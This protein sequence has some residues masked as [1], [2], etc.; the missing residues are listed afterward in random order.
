VW[1]GGW[2]RWRS[3]IMLK[4]PL[5]LHLLGRGALRV[6]I[7]HKCAAEL[8]STCPP[9]A[10]GPP[11]SSTCFACVGHNQHSLRS[12]GC[13]PRDVDAYCAAGGDRPDPV[14]Q[15]GVVSRNSCC[16]ATCGRCGGPSCGHLPGGAERCCSNAVAA[17]GRSCDQ[18]GPPCVIAN[19]PPPA[20]PPDPGDRE[21]QVH[22]G[23]AG[24]LVARVAEEFV[25]FNID[26]SQLGRLDLSAPLL[27][28]LAKALGPAHLR[29]GGTQADYNVYAFGAY[30]GFDCKRPP[31]PMTSY[32]CRVVTPTMWTEL[33]DFVQQTDL[34]L[35]YGLNNL[36]GRP[37]KTSPETKLCGGGDPAMDACPVRNQSNLEALLAWTVHS[38]P[39]AIFGL[40]LGNELNTCL[41]GIA[42]AQTQA[43]DF[44]ALGAL[45]RRLWSGQ[46]PSHMPI[47]IG[48]DT[49]SAVEYHLQNINIML[50]TTLE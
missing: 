15:R 13:S 40:E 32:R 1:A 27:I 30:A 46:A 50:I 42:G 33:L 14:C 6:G 9:P 34:S 45:L 7:P 31:T 41:N 49:H 48:P 17:A 37:T 2:P 24:G 3:Q 12:A 18:H 35:V 16:A 38:S 22:V 11:P 28:R 10:S 44:A 19:H 21:C 23:L 36:F 25:S 29:V 20:P 8:A 4:L 39:S 5:L 47:L 43:D 26:A